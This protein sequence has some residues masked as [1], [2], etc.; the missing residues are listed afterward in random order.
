M[1]QILTVL[2][3]TL[4]VQ[5]SFAQNNEATIKYNLFKGD[6]VA[7][8]YDAAYPNLIWL[9]DNAPKLSVNIYKYGAKVA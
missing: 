4:A 2:L 1:K 5:F 6:A 7:K 8:K 9:L 3:L